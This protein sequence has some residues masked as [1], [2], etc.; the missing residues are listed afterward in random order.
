MSYDGCTSTP[1]S[2]TQGRVSGAH[3]KD[4]DGDPQGLSRQKADQPGPHGSPQERGHADDG[5]SSME[6]GSRSG[7]QRGPSSDE[8][9]GMSSGNDSGERESHPRSCGHQSSRSSHSSSNGKD[10]G[11]MLESNKR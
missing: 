2:S 3:L 6:G 10:S 4:Q 9:E 1:S 11:L 7:D 5:V 8:M